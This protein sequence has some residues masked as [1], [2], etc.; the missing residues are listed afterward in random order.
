MRVP[1]IYYCDLPRC[2]SRRRHTV[3][4]RAHDGPGSLEF[5]LP[6]EALGG[7]PLAFALLV[8]LDQSK[9]DH[10]SIL[11]PPRFVGRRALFSPGSSAIFPV[12]RPKSLIFSRFVGYFPGSSAEEPYFLLVRRSNIP[13]FS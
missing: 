7:Q 2:S 11:F 1:E 13:I 9:H 10:N 4:N 5:P 12:R 8:P 6:R 3:A